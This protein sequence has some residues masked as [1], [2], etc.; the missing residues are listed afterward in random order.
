M[1]KTPP[2][3]SEKME[4][5][6]LNQCLYES[7]SMAI[8]A[9]LL[10]EYHFFDSFNRR[11]WEAMVST[12]KGGKSPDAVIVHELIDK[13]DAPRFTQLV[14]Y[15]EAIPGS[16]RI[17]DRCEHLIDLWRLRELRKLAAKIA[18]NVE[19]GD[20]GSD[21]AASAMSEIGSLS[22][23]TGHTAELFPDVLDRVVD[24]LIAIQDRSGPVGI[25]TGYK[26]LDYMT[27][28]WRNGT[29]VMLSA[30]PS[31]GKS[32]LA[33]NFALASAKAGIPTG[34]V[35]LEMT[36]DDFA[37]RMIGR[38]GRIEMRKFSN[39]AA[40][41]EEWERL[42]N[43][44]S[45]DLRNL[46]IF[47]NSRTFRI[48]KIIPLIRMWYHMNGVRLVIIDYIQ[49]MLTTTDPSRQVLELGNI[50]RE[51][52]MLAV[53]LGIPIIVLSQLNR[54]VERR[55]PPR[56]KLADMR[57]S[58]RLEEDADIVVGM[59]RPDFYGMKDVDVTDPHTGINRTINAEGV[60]EIIVLK[61]R[62][63]PTGDFVLTFVKKFASFEE[64][65]L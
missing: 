47:I 25:P 50:S 5:A 4:K 16:V 37:D 55:S 20:S 43:T 17:D 21:V 6:V 60:A 26:N 38:E 33:G 29:L 14:S 8:A 44:V 30:R 3:H 34:I 62:R 2:A 10:S 35:S 48:E 58:G 63:G 52:K 49:L 1:F 46:P 11:V 53:E 22:L 19:S 23:P 61:N 24:E 41:T 32:A 65:H 39:R 12:Y 57:G 64:M 7:D 31:Q 15:Y 45:G 13:T 59:W 42:T 27:G 36:T 28:G 51:L 9:S 18:Q 40:N 54:D 56:P